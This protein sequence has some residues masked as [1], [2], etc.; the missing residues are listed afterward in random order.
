ML[1]GRTKKLSE[2]WAELNPPPKY[3]D[4][5]TVKNKIYDTIVY[6]MKSGQKSAMFDLTAVHPYQQVIIKWLTEE[7]KLDASIVQVER[8]VNPSTHD[9]WMVTVFLVKWK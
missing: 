7:H 8:G 3:Q 2:L 5:N 4:I 1:E 6:A 9:P